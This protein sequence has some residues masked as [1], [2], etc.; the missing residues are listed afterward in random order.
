VS[1][2]AARR[3]V[4][5]V[6]E[7]VGNPDL[8]RLELSWGAFFLI[9]WTTLIGLSVWAFEA[10]GATA[11]GIMGFARLLP[12]ALAMPFG[13]WAADRFPRQRVVVAVFA[14][15][16]VVLTVALVAM[17]LEAPASVVY[18]VAA[19]LGVVA[20][21]CRP[22][23]RALVPV[24]ARSPEELVAANVALGTLDGVATLVG[25]LL[26]G[27]VLLGG[28]PTAVL[29]LAAGASLG[30]LAAMA[31]MTVPMDP[32]R[33][34]RHEERPVESLLGGVHEL[35]GNPDLALIVGCFVAQL[36]VR[37]VLGV[38]IV[39]VSFEL[40]DQGGSGVGW[41]GMAMGAGGL[42]GSLLSVGLT[43]RRRL[44]TPFALGLILWG[45]PI[46]VIGALPWAVVAFA[47]LAV[48]GIGNAVL[49]VA[50]ITFMQRN[51]EDRALARIFGVTYTLGT[52]TAGL[53]AIT[54]PAL[55]DSIGLQPTLIA[56]GALLPLLAVA[57]RGRLRE[58]DAR[59]DQPPES[60][61]V[62]AALPLLAP[63][64]PTTLEKIAARARPIDV[65]PGAVIVSEGEHGD[66][67]YA[68]EAGEV[69]VSRAG[70]AI[71]RLHGGDHFGEIA[72]VRGS[73]RTASV[74]AVV[75]TR[76]V[77]LDGR[78]LLD[79]MSCSHDVLS[80]ARAIS[81]ER[82]PAISCSQLRDAT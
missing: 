54:A 11:V 2:S 49:D 14:G 52:A 3:R 78:D 57:V 41:S 16:T 48:V 10:D 60:L 13:S 70:T 72:L 59:S 22:A 81:D 28:E 55:V 42:V 1:P 68:I 20:A 8:R 76:L 66:R 38:L 77:T 18:L 25:P 58:V 75:P 50:G 40:L 29:A 51:G 7:V 82:A 65:P 46:A 34:V 26:A 39:A 80:A 17:A 31:H 33:V 45:L 5:A 67:F 79:A 24:L 74:T 6:A 44:G 73:T 19:L 61:G 27:L 71:A 62:I 56:A 63:L 4:S 35:H 37:G 32:S 15:L 30:G 36:F 43:G 64:P 47:A 21:P 23:Q 9:E 12:G 69:E 53:G